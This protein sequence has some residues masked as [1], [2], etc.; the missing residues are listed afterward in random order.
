VGNESSDPGSPSLETSSPEPKRN[1]IMV[2][3]EENS[4]LE[5]RSNVPLPNATL[6]ILLGK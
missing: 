3:P 5:G 6:H 1:Q 4:S 2:V